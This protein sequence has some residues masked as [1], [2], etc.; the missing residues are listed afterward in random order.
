MLE[1]AGLGKKQISRILDGEFIPVPYS[2]SLFQKKLKTIERNEKDS[3]MNKKRRIEEDFHYPKDMFEDVLDDLDGTMM[4]KNF[5]YDR[6]K[7]DNRSELITNEQPVKVAQTLKPK[8]E[9]PPLPIQPQATA[10]VASAP[11]LNYNQLPEA[12]KYKTVFPNG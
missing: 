9:T 5:F 2:D 10:V 7:D 8:M 3:G 1:R 12:E 6:K 11:S 4:D